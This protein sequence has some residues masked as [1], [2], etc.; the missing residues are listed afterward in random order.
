VSGRT[1]ID[2]LSRRLGDAACWLFLMAAAISVYEV[3]VDWVF[4]APTVWV[5]DSTIM[6]CATAFMLGGAYAMQR[7]DH[8]RITVVYDRFGPR[9]K[10]VCDLITLSLALVYILALTWFT[11]LQAAE[12]IAIVERSGRAWD[13]PMPMVIRT[14]FFA[15]AALLALQTLANLYSRARER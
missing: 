4:R 15:G 14:A 7:R 2:R 5:H 8:V 3:V 11:G 6:L 12:S 10:R 9:A 1:P 13:F